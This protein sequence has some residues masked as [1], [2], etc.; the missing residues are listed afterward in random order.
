MPHLSLSPVAWHSHALLYFVVDTALVYSP[1][2]HDLHSIQAHLVKLKWPVAAVGRGRE[3]LSHAT[4]QYLRLLAS[5]K[6][7]DRLAK[8]RHERVRV[9]AWLGRAPPTSVVTLAEKAINRKL[10]ADQRL[11][12][13]E[14][15]LGEMRE[16]IAT[17]MARRSWMY[18]MRLH[19]WSCT[20][21]HTH[22]TTPPSP[23]TSG[24]LPSGRRLTP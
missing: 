9:S 14:A 10:P 4:T 11:D 24:A 18:V 1:R 21:R 15:A 2:L 19:L 16:T 12:A 6:D 20:L 5:S 22:T 3:H 13:A 8:S 23:L 17:T 7:D